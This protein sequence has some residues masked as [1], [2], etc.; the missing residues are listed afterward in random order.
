MGRPRQAQPDRPA[1]EGGRTRRAA[2]LAAI[3]SGE[4]LLNR[5]DWR[6]AGESL[7]KASMDKDLLTE[8]QR[9]QL[10]ALVAK[11][12]DLKKKAMASATTRPPR[13]RS[14]PKRPSSRM[15]TWP[16][17]RSSSRSSTSRKRATAEDVVDLA[18]VDF[19]NYNYRRGD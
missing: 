3:K 10:A 15:T 11:D 19:D 18:R 2:A 16:S 7:N 6:A 4:D 1:P 8:A 9:T 12:A 13:P 14:P 17:S 5:N